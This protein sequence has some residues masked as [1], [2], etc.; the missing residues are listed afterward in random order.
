MIQGLHKHSTM[1]IKV[2]LRLTSLTGKVLPILHDFLR[3]LENF[4]RLASISP[5]H[6][7]HKN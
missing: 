3:S 7:E 6:T 2:V 5:C 1:T 4:G